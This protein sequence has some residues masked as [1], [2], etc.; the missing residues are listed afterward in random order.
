MLPLPATD[1]QIL[2][3]ILNPENKKPWYTLASLL[4][5]PVTLDHHQIDETYPSNVAWRLPLLQRQDAT[6][7]TRIYTAWYHPYHQKVYTLTGTFEDSQRNVVH[8]VDVKSAKTVSGQA[9]IVARD[10][11]RR[12]ERGS[13]YTSTQTLTTT[14]TAGLMEQMSGFSLNSLI[15][16]EQERVI[17]ANAEGRK[18]NLE[19]RYPIQRWPVGVQFKQDGVRGTISYLGQHA[20]IYSRKNNVYTSV[21]HINKAALSLQPFLP[22]SVRP[23]GEIIID[24]AKLQ[25]IS[26][27]MRRNVLDNPEMFKLQFRIFDLQF[28]GLPTKKERTEKR[29]HAPPMEVRYNIYINALRN[30]YASLPEESCIDENGI[31][32]P[33]R[34]FPIITGLSLWLAWNR[35]ELDGYMEYAV[36]Q[37]QEGV[38]IRRLAGTCTPRPDIMPPK[39][40]RYYMTVAVYRKEYRKLPIEQQSGL[41]E[42][43]LNELVSDPQRGMAL[44]IQYQA[45]VPASVIEMSRHIYLPE[46][47]WNLAQQI[48]HCALSA[49]TDISW[50]RS[51][52]V[53][54]R[55]DHY[56]KLKPIQDAEGTLINMIEGKGTKTGMVA[57]LE[58][59]FRS[60]ETNQEVTFKAGMTGIEAYLTQLWQ[61]WQ[62][63]QYRAQLMGKLVT[64]EFLSYSDKGIP[65]YAKFKTFRDY[66]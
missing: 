34:K 32:G 39:I 19:F 51:M 58:L 3:E 62:H 43:I 16:K 63:P 33:S 22:E 49:P 25:T 59:S 5:L 21:P 10:F 47:Q 41:F 20:E 57:S 9:Y 56:L 65:L 61:Q 46:P 30:W 31:P 50:N 28:P 35:D 15:A 40:V 54:K 27:Y 64:F 55:A 14:E 37:N 8:D 45:N 7:K 23:E 26:G 17:K 13:D 4:E 12:S 1:P 38:I 48:Q 66:E 2:T 60:P 11:W 53:N 18:R 52:Y 36:A 29:I 6:G 44:L 42:H 24:G